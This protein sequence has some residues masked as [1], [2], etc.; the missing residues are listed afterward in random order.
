M[1][2]KYVSDTGGMFGANCGSYAQK[3]FNDH[4][5]FP[6]LIDWA[7]S[8]K[9]LIAFETCPLDCSGEWN[10]SAPSITE[11]TDGYYT[12]PFISDPAT[13]MNGGL[14]C[15]EIAKRN[16]IPIN[17]N[18]AATPYFNNE[19]IFT[20]TSMIKKVERKPSIANTADVYARKRSDTCATI[21]DTESTAN[22]I[23]EISRQ[24]TTKN[25]IVARRSK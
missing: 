12:K 24:H 19:K 25:N 3:I 20:R 23:S 9:E 4:K 13:P 7:N 6:T 17:T 16:L 8:N 18:T 15:M 2:G 14:S 5:I 10:N 21:A 1:I 22:R 11:C